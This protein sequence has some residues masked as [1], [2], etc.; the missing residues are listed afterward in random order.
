MRIHLQ[1]VKSRRVNK[2]PIGESKT[3]AGA[4]EV[5]RLLKV[6]ESLALFD[7][8]PQRFAVSTSNLCEQPAIHGARRSRSGSPPIPP[9]QH[10]T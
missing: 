2:A 8:H 3:D 4:H 9:A 6:G 1:A 7:L 5:A 10:S